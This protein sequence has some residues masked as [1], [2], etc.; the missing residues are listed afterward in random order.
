MKR[1]FLI[2]MPGAGKTTLGHELASSMSL[3]FF[4]L[5]Q[6]IERKEKRSIPEIF[7]IYGE[8]YFRKLEKEMLRSIIGDQEELILATGGGTPCFYHN[9]DTMN[10]AGTTV[11]LDVEI[12]ELIRRLKGQRNRPLLNVKDFEGQLK[13]LLKKRVR[14]YEKA[15]VRF[16]ANSDLDE[17][18][19]QLDHI[20]M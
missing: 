20:K 3:P 17:I 10:D 6:E 1:F 2:G 12:P 16:S 9:M 18:L 4:D 13:T 19:E 11:F 14:Y 5:D 15:K 7:L 8:D